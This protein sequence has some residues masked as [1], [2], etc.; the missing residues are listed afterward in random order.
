MGKLCLSA[1]QKQG[2]LNKSKDSQKNKKKQKS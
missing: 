2:A 1:K